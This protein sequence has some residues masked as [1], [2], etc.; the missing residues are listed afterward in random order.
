[1]IE[2]P[3]H[4]WECTAVKVVCSALVVPKHPET[5]QN[6]AK[7]HLVS[8][9]L[10]F[11]GN[12]SACKG[13]VWGFVAHLK[14]ASSS[15][16]K[17]SQC[18]SVREKA[19]LQFLHWDPNIKDNFLFFL[20]S[21]YEVEIYWHGSHYLCCLKTYEKQSRE[22]NKLKNVYRRHQD[23]WPMQIVAPIP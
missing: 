19:W 20:D 10:V 5:S 2:G 7:L 4:T 9:S 14:H 12:R 6:F 3:H 15:F 1:M 23:S 8:T 22:R 18:N 13:L 17:S 16:K 11:K 21:E